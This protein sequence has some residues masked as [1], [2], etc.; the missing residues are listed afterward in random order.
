MPTYSEM[1]PL[2][3]VKAKSAAEHWIKK[4]LKRCSG[5]RDKGFLKPVHL[6]FP[7]SPRGQYSCRFPKAAEEE[8]RDTISFDAYFINHPASSFVYL[9]PVIP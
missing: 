5:K 6:S 8:L 9:L 3:G 1:L 7:P 2:L 4:L